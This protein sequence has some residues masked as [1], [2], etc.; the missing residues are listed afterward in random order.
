[1]RFDSAREIMNAAEENKELLFQGGRVLTPGGL[2]KTGVRV[3]GALISAVGDG[4]G[5]SPESI[6]LE[7][8][9][10]LPGMVE[11]HT[12]NLERHL[13]P[14]PE[15]Y[16]SD[17]LGA[18]EAHDAQMVASGIT[19]VFDSVCVGESVDKGREAMLKM[20]LE[21]YLEGREHAR[22]RHLLHIRCE[23]SDADMERLFTEA[24]SI[25]SPDMVSVMDHTPWQ[26]QWRELSDWARYNRK[27]ASLEELEKEALKIKEIRDQHAAKNI[28]LV[29]DYARERNI[30][31]A[32]HDDT[33]TSHIE[34]A[35]DL[36]AVIS[37]F[38]T[39]LEAAA[40]AAEAGLTVIMGT[41]NLIRESSH[42][43]NVLASDVAKAGHLSCLSSDYVPSSLI[44]GAFSLWRKHG[45][46]FE[47]AY[48]SVSRTPAET[49]GLTDRGSIAP[50]LKADLLRVSFRN[51]RPRIEAVWVGG[52]RVY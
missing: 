2:R 11:L 26:R 34:D 47:D 48:A 19:T 33:E 30:P 20:S 15:I 45:Y 22:A 37:E 9:Y 6:D 25:A 29:K 39:T 18:M 27:H 36:G 43:G 46:G 17:A 52:R 12:D 1:M 21:A 42:S 38:P 49:A 8:D 41:P 24:L 3:E 28:R 51:K 10:L 14:R 31:L 35:L 23:I 16:W 13:M 32:T 40:A 4:L 50:G 7:G 5:D 44:H